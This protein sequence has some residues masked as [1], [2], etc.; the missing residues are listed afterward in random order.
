M[1]KFMS[2]IAL[3]TSSCFVPRVVS[4]GR[5][6][7]VLLCS[8]AAVRAHLSRRPPPECAPRARCTTR[9]AGRGRGAAGGGAGCR[10]QRRE[11]GAVASDAPLPPLLAACLVACE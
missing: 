2:L 6:R 5:R 10:G 1:F 8:V 4:R 11:E 7:K 9:A 3:C